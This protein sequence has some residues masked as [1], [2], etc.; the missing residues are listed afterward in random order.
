MTS[1]HFPYPSGYFWNSNSKYTPSTSGQDT[2]KG[3]DLPTCLKQ[4]NKE[5]KGNK[6]YVT[7]FRTPVIRIKKTMMLK[8]QGA[9]WALWLFHPIHLREIQAYSTERE[10]TGRDQLTPELWKHSRKPR[11]PRHLE[12]QG[13]VL[14][15]KDLHK[16]KPGNLETPREYSAESWSNPICKET[17]RG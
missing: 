10:S 9:K 5:T 14:E 4:T 15:R 11:W 7:V 16:E 6:I 1:S 13:R 2:K 8:R 17:T 3:T 12:S